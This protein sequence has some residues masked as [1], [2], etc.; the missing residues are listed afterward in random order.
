MAHMPTWTLWVGAPSIHKRGRQR[1]H[2]PGLRLGAWVYGLASAFGVQGFGFRRSRGPL[3]LNPKPS[4]G[5]H[6]RL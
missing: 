3:S 2:V 4:W 5:P 6:K 1:D